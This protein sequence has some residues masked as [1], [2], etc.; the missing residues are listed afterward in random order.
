MQNL[1]LAVPFLLNP[2]T[3]A[4]G[5]AIGVVTALI[6]GLMPIVQAANIRPLNVI[7]DLSESRGVSSVVLTIALLVVLSV[8]FCALAIVILNNAVVLGIAAVYGTFAFL[9]VLSVFFG[10]VVFVVSKLPVPEHF[11]LKYLALILV[12]VA[13]SV[14][15]YLVL[16]VFGI[17]LFA[18]SLVTHHDD[19]AGT[20]HRCLHHWAGAGARAR[21]A[22]TD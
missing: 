4:G 19:H 21:P 13:A 20:V 14:L 17:L 15:L 6:F 10:L 3:I 9:L 12:G 2:W 11:D 1:G 7:R 8:L 5:V 16:P 22:N 18:A